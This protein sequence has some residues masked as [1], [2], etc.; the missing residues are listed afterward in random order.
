MDKNQIIEGLCA[1]NPD[2]LYERADAVRREYMGNSVL[3]RVIIE[4]SNY[5][6]RN[7]L[8]CGLRKS[9]CMVTRYRMTP[10]EI[11]DTCRAAH[12]LGF[13]TVV[14]QSGEDELFAI[15]DIADI[16]QTIKQKF[17]LAITLSI[18]ERSYDEYR[19]LRDAG[20]DRYL[21]RI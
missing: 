5:C 10:S 7:C 16:V 19:M 11:I 15:E 13:K 6:R 17:G 14:L 18:G 3:V 20:T 1:Q 12:E 8:Y 2:S 4:F 9:N 21:M